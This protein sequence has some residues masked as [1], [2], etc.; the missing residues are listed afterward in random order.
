MIEKNIG[1]STSS[2]RHAITN[3]TCDHSLFIIMEYCAKGDLRTL[4]RNQ[5]SSG[6][7]LLLMRSS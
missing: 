7:E 2:D 5:R 3:I 1:E 4:I 6:Y